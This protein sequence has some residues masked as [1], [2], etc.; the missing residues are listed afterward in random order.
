MK[1]HFEQLMTTLSDFELK[2]YIN[3]LEKYTPEAITA[4]INELKTRGQLFSDKELEILNKKIE[5]KKSNEEEESIFRSSKSLRKNIVNDQN[6]PLFYSQIAILTFS[7]LF[8]VIFGA[9]LFSLNLDNNKNKIKVLGFGTLCTII[10]IAIGN[11][12]PH[13]TF[14]ILLA[15]GGGG[16]FLSTDSWNKYIGRETKYRTKPIWIPIIISIIIS[17]LLLLAMIYK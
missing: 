9:I 3:K 17:A 10:A 11:L 7:T 5:M 8:T 14:L 4:A 6:A 15:N 1:T 12:V 13:S 2:E 16:Y